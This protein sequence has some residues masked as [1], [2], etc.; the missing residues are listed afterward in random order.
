MLLTCVLHCRDDRKFLQ[1]KRKGLLTTAGRTNQQIQLHEWISRTAFN[2]TFAGKKLRAV[3]R[4]NQ[5]L[6]NSL[7]ETRTK[8]C[9]VLSWMEEAVFS[10]IN[11]LFIFIIS[12]FD[13][14]YSKTSHESNVHRL[15]VAS[16]IDVISFLFLTI[17]TRKEKIKIILWNSSISLW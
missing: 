7:E 10:W 11:P 14:I 3:K 5:C 17:L 8:T 13:L 12:L 16:L 6:K 9:L 1:D 4:E 15:K 2:S